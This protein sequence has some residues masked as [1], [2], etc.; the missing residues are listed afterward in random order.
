MS[1]EKS[2]IFGQTKNQLV[3]PPQDGKKR[4]KVP[5]FFYNLKQMNPFAKKQPKERDPEAAA[6]PAPVTTDDGDK[7]ESKELLEKGEGEKGDE[8]KE[9]EKKDGEKGVEGECMI[10]RFDRIMRLH[11]ICIKLP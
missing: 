7:E 8:D 2:N 5:G 4:D 3:C 11:P 1:H 6:A 9:A 10:D